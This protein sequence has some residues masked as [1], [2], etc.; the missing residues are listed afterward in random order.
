MSTKAAVA[1]ILLILLGLL[2]GL[3][4]IVVALGVARHIR[5]QRNATK[6]IERHAAGEAFDEDDSGGRVRRPGPREPDEG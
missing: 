3:V 5:R 6:R 1:T 4:V 2:L